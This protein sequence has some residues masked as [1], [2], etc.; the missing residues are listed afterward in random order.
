M[1]EKFTDYEKVVTTGRPAGMLA[2]RHGFKSVKQLADALPQDARVLDVGAGA[3]PFGEEVA[4]LRPDILWI[5]F[6]QCYLDP[7]ISGEVTQNSP[8]NVLHV[9]GDATRLGETFG[10]ESFDVVFS[11]WLLPHLSL[12][13]RKPA[14]RVARA[15]FYVTKPGGI[16]S[17][18]PKVS[19]KKLPKIKSGEA[20]KVIKDKT[21][22]ADSYSDRIVAETKLN[23]LSR[24]TNQL[25][26]DQVIPF[27]GT[28]RFIKRDGKFPQIYHPETHEFISPFTRKG[29]QTS[30]RL[31]VAMV[32][33]AIRQ[34]KQSNG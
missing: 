13:N 10:P 19:D 24:K 31:L 29:M 18:G 17:V 21:V 7:D 14:E 26:N 25:V 33:H 6:D 12:V 28:S 3:S 2:N 20:I 30:G 27:F 4:R 8:T 1:T 23:K 15:I 11:Y 34:R 16:M 32:L 22:S 5:N 9:A